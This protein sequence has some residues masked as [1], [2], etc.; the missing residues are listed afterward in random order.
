M[1]HFHPAFRRRLVGL[2]A[3]PVLLLGGCEDVNEPTSGPSTGALRGDGLFGA[4][5]ISAVYF[6]A[7]NE[8][9]ERALEMVDAGGPFLTQEFACSG[10]GSMTI[11]LDQ[12]LTVATVSFSNY[13]VGCTAPTRLTFN[14]FNAI[15]ITFEETDPGLRFSARMLFNHCTGGA[16][17]EGVV[18][19]L[20]QEFGNAILFVSAPG[21]IFSV[22]DCDVDPYGQGGGL[23]YELTGTRAAGGSLNVTGTVRMEDDAGFLIV[24]E[25][26]LAY[27]YDQSRTPNIAEWPGGSFELASYGAPAGGMVI[28]GAVAGFPVDIFFDGFGGATFEFEDHTC[29]TNLITGENPCEEL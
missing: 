2:F 11:S 25:L 29:Q 9:V 20:P 24:E 26:D 23:D 6:Q 13:V 3:L 1:A 17:P 22:F 15:V 8:I 28:G 18:M 27:D 16:P 19:Q 21:N 7:L 14:G 4:S 10:D 5:V 12:T